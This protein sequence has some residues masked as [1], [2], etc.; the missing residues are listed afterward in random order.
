MNAVDCSVVIATYNR[1]GLLA[2]TLRALEAQQVPATVRWEI[3]VVDNNSRDAT[4]DVVQRFRKTAAVT[5]RYEFEPRQGQSFARNRGIEST[6]GGVVLFT[7]DDIIPEPNW[8]WGM[9]T[10]IATG[11]Y[12][13]AGGRVLPR[14]EA[15]VPRW[16]VGRRDLQSWLAL[17]D[18]GQPGTLEY[19]L[20]EAN[21]IV[22]ASMG[23]R[24]ELFEEFGLFPTSLGHRGARMY[25]G[26][27]VVFINRVLFKGRRIRYDPSIVV[28]HR[29]RA[30][31]LRRSFFLR[32]N[33]DHGCGQA[34]LVPPEQRPGLRDVL[35]T[36][37]VAAARTLRGDRDALSLQLVLATELGMVWGSRRWTL[38]R[39]PR[40]EE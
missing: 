31:R 25:G 40:A 13:G 37:R 14:W 34:Q 32:R 10:T 11:G 15:E 2:D 19:P 38:R 5:V 20:V 23:F 9:Y 39:H 28:H 24:R 3:V 8:V 7:D 17:V 1:A 6:A 29:I 4:R 16:L 27:E 36:L 35:R 33:F 21:R 30:D 22:G 18:T 26:E 12:D